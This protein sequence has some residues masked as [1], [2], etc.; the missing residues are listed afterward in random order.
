[1]WCVPATLLKVALLQECFSRFLICT[2]GTKSRKTSLWKWL[3]WIATKLLFSNE[4]A[5][6]ELEKFFSVAYICSCRYF[7][8]LIFKCFHQQDVAQKY[9]ENFNNIAAASLEGSAWFRRSLQVVTT[10]LDQ[11]SEFEESSIS[12]THSAQD[13]VVTTSPSII[14]YSTKS[15]QYS[16][17][18]ILIMAEVE[19]RPYLRL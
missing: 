5:V 12:D 17:P 8:F 15:S 19:L 18:A 11:S 4:E 9:L 16:I 2:N 10:Q 14:S 1:M 6:K 7:S 3:Q 13:S